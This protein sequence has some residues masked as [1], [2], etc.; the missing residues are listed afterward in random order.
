MRNRVNLKATYWIVAALIA[1]YLVARAACIPPL[2]DE[3]TT[4]FSYVQTGSF[5]PYYSIADPNNHIL[6]SFLAHFSYLLFGD[7]M[8]A[9]RIPNL[10]AFALYAW[11]GF[12]FLK[13]FKPPFAG[14]VWIAVLFLNPGFI[15]Y[16]GLCRGYGISFALLLVTLYYLYK[17]VDDPRPRY[18]VLSILSNMLMIFANLTMLP[19]SLMIA[20]AG[21][22]FFLC[23][24]QATKQY[25]LCSIPVL[26]YGLAFFY[27]YGFASLLKANGRFY[28]SG[29]E[30]LQ[31]ALITTIG[32]D[33][34]NTGSGQWLPYLLLIAGTVLLLLNVRRIGMQSL[35][36]PVFIVGACAAMFI[37]KKYMGL[38]YPPAR[39]SMHLVLLLGLSVVVLINTNAIRFAEYVAALP[40]VLSVYLTV[41]SFNLHYA[42]S[43]PNEAVPY[44]FVET[45]KAD[46]IDNVVPA[47]VSC[48]SYMMSVWNYYNYREGNAIN[49][50]SMTHYPD[51][52]ADYIVLS[53]WQQVQLPP[54]YSMVAEYAPTGHKLMKKQNT[55]RRYRNVPVSDVS[56]VNYNG[57]PLGVVHLSPGDSGCF[58]IALT[59]ELERPQPCWALQ[60]IAHAQQS[61]IA[62]NVN[63]QS[64]KEN[65]QVHKNTMLVHYTPQDTA[66]SIGFWHS[67]SE[68]CNIRKFTL[69]VEEVERLKDVKFFAGN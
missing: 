48:D 24:K 65:N 18:F 52:C 28:I 34:S 3:L 27:L 50:A 60:L 10:L 66:I 39:G 1:I 37:S 17:S 11:Y 47:T 45:V 19:L 14:A 15:T 32:N 4:F 36:F 54:S 25:L 5:Q 38:N 59:Y 51:T 41:I 7:S 30:T 9:L 21:L 44:A 57:T 8:F 35:L 61:N 29:G 46:N 49:Q 43:W 22:F 40:V 16:F 64:I 69:H 68:P 42:A 56:V 2:M 55:D 67:D 12:R 31:E 20:G 58:R 23:K 33:I 53:G 63:F 13:E 26:L 6:N 62:E